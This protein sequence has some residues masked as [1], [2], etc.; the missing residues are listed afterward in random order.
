MPSPSSP[1]EADHKA[2]HQSGQQ[3]HLAANP[4]SVCWCAHTDNEHGERKNDKSKLNMLAVNLIE[5]GGEEDEVIFHGEFPFVI[6]VEQF[7]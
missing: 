7:F 3:Y 2:G 6:W 5:G 1:P 4:T